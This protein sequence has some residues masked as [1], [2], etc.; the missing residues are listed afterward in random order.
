PK[1]TNTQMAVVKFVPMHLSKNTA[2]TWSHTSRRQATRLRRVGNWYLILFA[3]QS[4][5]AMA[6][7]FCLLF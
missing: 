6:A 2:G 4:Q 7:F 3:P 5:L 1:F